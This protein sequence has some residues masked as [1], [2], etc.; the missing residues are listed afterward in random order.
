MALRELAKKL[1]AKYKVNPYPIS[2]VMDEMYAHDYDAKA[3]DWDVLVQDTKDLGITVNNLW[4]KIAE[5]Y[6]MTRP[7]E[8][9][10]QVELRAVEDRAAALEREE[11]QEMLENAISRIV[12]AER[13]TIARDI[14]AELR[15]ITE[16]L[17]TMSKKAQITFRAAVAAFEETMEKREEELRA[18]IEKEATGLRDAAEFT[19]KAEI[20]CLRKQLQEGLEIPRSR[21]ALQKA[22]ERLKAPPP[23]E[24]LVPQ[25]WTRE[26]SVPVTESEKEPHTG[27]TIEVIRCLDIPPDLA[28]F[29]DPDGRLFR[30]VGKKTIEVSKA[31][32]VKLLRPRMPSP[33][34][35]GPPPEKIPIGQPVFIVSAKPI[36]AVLVVQKADKIKARDPEYFRAA[37][38]QGKTLQMIVEE[39]EAEKGPVE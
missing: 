22:Q 13:A 23:P 36:N 21:P 14:Y 24:E 15:E 35:A 1:G 30:V 27:K 25:G 6:E 10:S 8:E 4:S 12:E 39:Y 37:K 16:E 29:K 9:V 31:E 5:Y 20:Q 28:I 2:Q 19:I 18:R 7:I 26:I 32:I 11:V 17:P 34:A 38:D 3:V 33:A